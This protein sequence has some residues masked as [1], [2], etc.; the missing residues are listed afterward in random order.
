MTNLRLSQ[1]M[2]FSLAAILRGL[3]HIYNL[4]GSNHN[5]CALI[6]ILICQNLGLDTKNIFLRLLVQK[7]CDFIGTCQ[8]NG[9]HL[10]FGHFGIFKIITFCFL[11]I[12]RT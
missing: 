2:D 1:N 6:G 3:G 10:G 4:K 12:P 7:L 8:E 5:N 9:G 11:L